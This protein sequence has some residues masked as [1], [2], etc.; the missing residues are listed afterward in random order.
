MAGQ[1]FGKWT[2]LHVTDRPEGVTNSHTY[3]LCK[4]QCGAERAVMGRSLR[5]GKSGGCGACLSG[6]VRDP[7]KNL[8]VPDVYVYAGE[9][10][11]KARH[12][13]GK[14]MLQVAQS[15]GMS[16]GVVMLYEKGRVKMALHHFLRFCS[17]VGADPVEMV[18]QLMSTSCMWD[19][20]R[21][22]K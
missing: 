2:V 8:S 5:S 22:S 4:C 16:E 15:L 18:E 20:R 13:S 14:T 19:I 17:C 3:W 9:M 12:D 11:R 10:L 7:E 6:G 1:V 21:N